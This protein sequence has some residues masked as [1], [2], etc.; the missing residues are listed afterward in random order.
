MSAD[1]I[2]KIV[3]RLEELESQRVNS[4]YLL[5][6]MD[7]V[8]DIYY[9]I[10][11]NGNYVFVMVAANSSGRTSVQET[12]ELVLVASAN[13]DL[14]ISGEIKNEC[15]HIL[16]CKSRK[17]LDV[18]AFVRLTKAFIS[19][20]DNNDG[21]ISE[22]FS[23]LVTLFSNRAEI[24]DASLQGLYAEMYFIWHSHLNGLEL[25]PKWR[26]KG[27]MKYDFSINET[28]KIEVKSSIGEMRIHHFSHE[29]IYANGLEIRI[30]SFLLRQDDSG[31][32]L[33]D[34]VER[35][36]K[37]AGSNYGQLLLIETATRGIEAETMSGL[38]YDEVYT[39][40]NIRAYY[41]NSLPHYECEQ[42]QGVSHTEY[43]ADLTMAPYQMI[44]ELMGWV[45]EVD[46]GA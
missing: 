21:S 30:A 12:S 41:A 1:S 5:F 43:D 38:R 11:P 20:A 7:D 10:D 15:V 16:V 9:G 8:D 17:L 35:C 24:S 13:C 23:S 31:L 45:N 33:D 46:R 29:Q 25:L 3:R 40:A 14:R 44:D 19:T 39:I 36:R 37:L 34:L 22:L 42:P 6:A 18:F 27:R 4:E 26:T 2:E 32:S 28:F